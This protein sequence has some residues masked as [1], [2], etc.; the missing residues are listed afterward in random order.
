MLADSGCHQVLELAAGL[1][2]R[3]ASVSRDPGMH[4]VEVDLPKVVAHKQKLLGRTAP[5]REVAARE[6]LRLVAGDVEEIALEDHV[7]QDGPV[8]VI[9]EGLLMYL[10][11]GQQQQLWSR[12]QSLLAARPGSKLVFDLVPFCE[13]RKG[14]MVGKLLEAMFK[15]ATRGR[16]FAFDERTRDDLTCEL[17]QC[18]FA[19]VDLVEPHNA[20]A[21]WN[22][23]FL[24]RLTQTLVFQ[25]AVSASRKDS[26]PA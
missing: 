11:A 9:A 4:Y 21:E 22:L 2:R 24:D 10:D 15:K 19:E 3:G 23:P 18:G 16:T 14:G 1:S 8:F 25:C 13:G 12:I 7:D 20:P 17:R 26:P 5:G 6:N